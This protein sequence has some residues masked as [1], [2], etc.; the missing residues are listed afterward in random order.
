VA[1]RNITA[2]AGNMRELTDV[3]PPCDHHHGNQT[4][5]TTPSIGFC[6]SGV[7]YVINSLET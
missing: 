5:D 4:A 6:S 1:K 2:V 3:A 7:N